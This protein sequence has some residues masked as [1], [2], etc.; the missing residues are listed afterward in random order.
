MSEIRVIE[1]EQIKVSVCDHG[2]ELVGL[3]DKAAE[4]E[5]IW[6]ADPKYW[7]RHA[8][9]LFPFVGNCNGKRYIYQ[10]KEY[11]MGQ[12]GFARDMEFELESLTEDSVTHVLKSTEE[13]YAKYPFT[14]ILKVTHTIKGRELAVKW[15]VTNTGDDMMYFS[16]GG[17][18]GFNVPVHEG[19]KK[20][21]YF[22]TFNG[23]ESLQ[24]ISIDLEAA[25]A[26]AEHPKTL[27]IRDNKV[28]VTEHMFDQDALVFDEHEV[29]KVGIAFPDGTPYVTMTCE[30]I[31]ST[32]VWSKPMPETP[33]ICLEPWIGRCDNKGFNGELKDKYG[34]QALEAGGTFHAQ[35]EITLG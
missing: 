14:F 20:T 30:Q 23:E 1:N 35:Y 7:N 2:A 24:Y 19:E 27:V 3:Y 34:V 28:P 10:G 11:P 26:D 8:P 32:G 18:P 9:I 25:A 17:H 29:K 5:V 16:I 12:H 4:W 13:T 22:I 33:F 6:Q 31:P 21:D 15:E